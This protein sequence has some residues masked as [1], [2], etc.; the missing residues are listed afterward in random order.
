MQASDVSCVIPTRGDVDLTRILES[1][2]F[3]DVIVWDN[4][5]ETDWGLFARYRAI[6]LAK[7]DVI[8]TQDD[9]VLITCWDELLA[10][11]KPGKLTVNYPEPWDIPWVAAGGIFDRNLP[12]EAFGKY[13]LKWP[14]DE[15]FRRRTCD[16][17]F[18]LLTEAVVIDHGYEDLP[19][20]YHGGRISTSDGWYDRDRPE[21]QRRCRELLAA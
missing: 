7:N 12:F 18:C 11:Y 8:A 15:T 6:E 13:L 14:D 4:S 21:A 16:A 2:P 20:G 17:V 9:D 1:L 3:D 5:K 10:A 19:H